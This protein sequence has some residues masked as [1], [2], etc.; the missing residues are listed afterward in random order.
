[1][2][3][4]LLLL[5]FF[6]SFIQ[7]EPYQDKIRIGQYS[8]TT[9]RSKVL[10]KDE[11]Y[12]CNWLTLYSTTGR[13][14]CGTLLDAKRN[15]TVFV[16][17]TYTVQGNKFIT[18]NYYHYRHAHEPDSSVK[19]FIQNSKGELKLATYTYYYNGNAIDK[20]PTKL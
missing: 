4:T 17:G 5:P 7:V 6:F 1:M 8:Y 13:V 11:W 2:I 20:L 12:Q 16:T 18:R 3:K 14:Q 10:L 9:K 15:D 19:V